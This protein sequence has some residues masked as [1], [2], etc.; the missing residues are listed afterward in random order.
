MSHDY[1][2]DRYRALET[3]YGIENQEPCIQNVGNIVAKVTFGLVISPSVIDTDY[4]PRR[5]DY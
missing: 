3:I 2:Q 4:V 5:V 1:E